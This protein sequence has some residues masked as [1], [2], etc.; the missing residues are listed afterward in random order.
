VLSVA[1]HVAASGDGPQGGPTVPPRTVNF[2]FNAPEASVDTTA[3]NDGALQPTEMEA[4]TRPPSLTVGWFASLLHS[5][6]FPG[7]L[8]AIPLAVSVTDAPPVSPVLGVTV[9]GTVAPVAA[10]ADT[11][12][13]R[14]VSPV[15]TSAVVATRPNLETARR[16]PRDRT[17]VRSPRVPTTCLDTSHPHERDEPSQFVIGPGYLSTGRSTSSLLRSLSETKGRQK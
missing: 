9:N 17:P 1:G 6:T 11:V 5:R 8:T 14:I 13:A 4:L 15:T 12:P 2:E 3:A 10:D 7:E 16:L